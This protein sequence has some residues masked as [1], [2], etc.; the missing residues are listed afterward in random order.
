MLWQTIRLLIASI[1][2]F[3]GKSGNYG[4]ALISLAIRAHFLKSP[5][6]L[7]R[8]C[9]QGQEGGDFPTWILTQ[10]EELEL[11]RGRGVHTPEMEST[12][13]SCP[14]TCD[15]TK[16]LWN[17]LAV[18]LST[19]KWRSKND[20]ERCV[21]KQWKSRTTF[22]ERKVWAGWEFVSLRLRCNKDTS[23]KTVTCRPKVV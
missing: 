15:L 2:K 23:L 3:G 19:I 16:S 22:S 13:L 21:G 11:E 4:R 5:K 8:F 18:S 7:P 9:H 12:Q 10:A 6:R 1:H 14:S 17:L 20:K